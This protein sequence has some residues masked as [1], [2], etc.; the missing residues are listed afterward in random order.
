[1][2]NDSFK[3]YV[4]PAYEESIK[5]NYIPGIA[6][7]INNK[8]IMEM[9][10]GNYANSE[11]L[12]RE[13]LSWYDKTSNK[14]NI[15]AT[16]LTLGYALKNQGS[17]PEAVSYFGKAYEY[18]KKTDDKIKTFFALEQLGSSYVESGDYEKA[19]ERYRES[20]QLILKLKNEYWTIIQ[21]ELLGQLYRKIEDYNT[22]LAY[23]RQAYQRIELP[24]I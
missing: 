13:S 3:Y 16:F 20:L 19:F 14:I 2:I 23:F 10:S 9:L 5:I 24:R 12:A 21:L 15:A 11:K 8:A 1:M 22:A 18:S 7:A 4:A 6:E 17:F